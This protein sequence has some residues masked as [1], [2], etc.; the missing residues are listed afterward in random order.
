M[1]SIAHA[2]ASDASSGPEELFMRGKTKSAATRPVAGDGE[3]RD[4]KVKRMRD[5]GS[6]ESEEE[7][8]E[9]Q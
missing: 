5:G 7:M 3:K 9:T 6:G 4:K 1:A 2:A 8:T